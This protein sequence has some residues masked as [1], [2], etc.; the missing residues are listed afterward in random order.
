MRMIDATQRDSR[1]DH[2]K[3]DV[4]RRI[5]RDFIGHGER[6]EEQFQTCGLSQCSQPFPM[7]P[8]ACVTINTL[9]GS[10][11]MQGHSTSAVFVPYWSLTT[12]KNE[13][14]DENLAYLGEQIFS[15]EC[16]HTLS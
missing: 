15:H 13:K 3:L 16:L 11:H 10:N 14:K 8:G 7:L 5:T 9:R 1:S 6:S 4:F 2:S 12:K